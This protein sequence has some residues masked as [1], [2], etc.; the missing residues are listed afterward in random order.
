MEEFIA[1]VKVDCFSYF[2]YTP[3]SSDS[4]EEAEPKRARSDSPIARTLSA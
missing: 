2:K 3:H 4:T 1:R